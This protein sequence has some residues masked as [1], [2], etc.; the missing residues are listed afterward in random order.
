MPTKEELKN[1][2]RKN[3]IKRFSN[4]FKVE[5]EKYIKNYRKKKDKIFTQWIIGEIIFNIPEKLA[6]IYE[7]QK[8]T[9]PIGG[10]LHPKVKKLVN[11]YSDEPADKCGR[12]LADLFYNLHKI[13]K[14]EFYIITKY[15]GI[16]I[17]GTV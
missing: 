15:Y 10:I 9:P 1:Y 8:G 13:P 6:I 2:C 4:K 16:T 5:L 3:N 14:K 11:K 7:T 17:K 12:D